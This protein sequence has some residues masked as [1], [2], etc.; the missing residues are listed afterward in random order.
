MLVITYDFMKLTNHEKLVMF[1]YLMIR[2]G[3]HIR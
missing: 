1:V 2:Q 3:F